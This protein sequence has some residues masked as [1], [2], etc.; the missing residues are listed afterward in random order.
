VRE[1]ADQGPGEVK[2]PLRF[3][4]PDP[5]PP[6]RGFFYWDTYYTSVGLW[7]TGRDDLARDNADNMLYLLETQGY[8]PNYADKAQ[9]NRSQPPHASIQVREVY[10][11]SR[12]KGWL[13]RA[14]GMLEK[15]YAFW[16]S[17]RLT[18]SGLNHYYTHAS[19]DD[20]YSFAGNI[21][22]RHH[23]V[24]ENPVEK[25]RYLT[26]IIAEAESG[27]DYTPRFDHRCTDFNP[28]DLNA[29]LYLHER[30][31]EHF[32]REL[33]RDGDVKR[34]SERAEKRRE[35]I[36]GHCWSEKDGFFY[37]YDLPNHRQFP[38][39][40]PAAFY[41]LWA[42]LATE[43]QAARM[44]ENLPA[45]ERECGLTTC[46]RQDPAGD[47]RGVYQWDDP[48]AWA[49]LHHA[50]IVGLTNYGYTQHAER[51]AR[52]WAASVASTYEQTGHLWEKYNAYN[53]SI[54]GV[55]NEYP[56]KPMLGWTA[57]VFLQA[58][59]VLGVI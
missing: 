5:K 55:T 49:P 30:N 32:A 17:M 23:P 6:F 52:K 44:V 34:W 9:L 4:C 22:Q 25:M 45:M 56:F 10:E 59:R 54:E 35:L 47:R 28:I 18:A 53:G 16:N 1:P 3:T 58:C 33:G 36:Q 38:L 24:P 57:G 15:E 2:L 27:W 7:L 51:I 14:Y 12:D 46:P 31:C 26:N 42:K 13:A 20:I 50:A 39:R 41:V 29:L 8:V 19:P 48:N 40:T 37:D 43:E 21:R 11:R